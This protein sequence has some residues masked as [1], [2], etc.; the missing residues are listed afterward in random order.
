MIKIERVHTGIELK[1]SVVHR[2]SSFVLVFRPRPRTTRTR[3]KYEHIKTSTKYEQSMSKK[4]R[5]EKGRDEDE[6][7]PISG[8]YY[9]DEDEYERI[10][11]VGTRTST[12]YEARKF[13]YEVRERGRE[14]LKMHNTAQPTITE[15][16][17]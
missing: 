14:K 2:L 12:K 3:T 7:E 8:S 9:E 16:H 15:L 5:D 1:T 10:L 17:C 6:Y 13:L 11:K 4:H